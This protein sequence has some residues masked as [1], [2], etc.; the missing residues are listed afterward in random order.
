MNKP[1]D[2]SLSPRCCNTSILPSDKLGFTSPLPSPLPTNSLSSSQPERY[3]EKYS[4][5][6]KRSVYQQGTCEGCYLL[7]PFI[8]QDCGR[9]LCLSIGSE[10]QV[11]QMAS[12]T[13]QGILLLH[14]YGDGLSVKSSRLGLGLR[15]RLGLNRDVDMNL[16]LWLG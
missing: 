8:I 11:K 6:I 15:L 4:L 3:S 2:S 16:G 5:P 14:N 10:P 7:R 12:F 1:G 9:M 13:S